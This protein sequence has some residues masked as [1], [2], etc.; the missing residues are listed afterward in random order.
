M[1]DTDP[2]MK[3][4]ADFYLEKLRGMVKAEPDSRLFLTLAEEL[5]KRDELKEAMAVLVA[6]IGRNPNFAAARLTLGRWYLRDG[7]FP[8]ARNE[9]ARVLELTPGDKF[10]LRYIKEADHKI[11]DVKGVKVIEKLNKFL[12][13]IR[14]AFADAPIK[15]AP[16]GGR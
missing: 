5:K 1:A 8:E 4:S 7:M 12:A 2:A 16:G 6:G 13:G 10:A 3:T 15:Q 11:G 9:F 14:K